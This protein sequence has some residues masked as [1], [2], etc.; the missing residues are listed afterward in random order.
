MTLKGVAEKSFPWN[1]A[2]DSR[3]PFLCPKNKVKKYRR[4]TARPTLQSNK[5]VFKII[6][7]I[8]III[9]INKYK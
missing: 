9:I 5:E 2:E 6:I 3:T 4:W 8:I 7:I 1:K